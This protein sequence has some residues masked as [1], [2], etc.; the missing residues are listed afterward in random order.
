MFCPQRSSSPSGLWARIWP[1]GPSGLEARGE[2]RKPRCAWVASALIHTYISIWPKN[3]LKLSW[4]WPWLMVNRTQK[5]WYEFESVA[6]KTA[7]VTRARTLMQCTIIGVYWLYIVS[8]VQWIV[9]LMDKILSLLE[10]ICHT[11]HANQCWRVCCRTMPSD[12]RVWKWNNAV[13][14]PIS[15]IC[16]ITF[17]F[18]VTKLLLISIIVS[19]V[20]AA[21]FSATD[22][23]SYHSFWVR[24]FS[25]GQTQLNFNW[26][27]GQIWGLARPLT[28]SLQRPL[29]IFIYQK[30]FSDC[31]NTFPIESYGRFKFAY[32]KISS[33]NTGKHP[34]YTRVAGQSWACTSMP[35]K[36]GSWRLFRT[37]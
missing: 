35:R 12:K 24:T 34:I 26:F 22:S 4:V 5:E 16:S 31:K 20:T 28:P 36:F 37:P 13:R 27:L 29:E 21:V 11:S 2:R 30:L 8:Y 10:L 6:E 1:P 23:N 3:Q 33:S 15:T 19:L 25:H 32:T 9:R 17:V 18:N 14:L 7:A